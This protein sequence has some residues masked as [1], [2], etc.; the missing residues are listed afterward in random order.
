MSNE[1]IDNQ[2]H[3]GA[4]EVTSQIMKNVLSS[5]AE[6]EVGS[7]F[8][9]AKNACP[10]V[11]TLEFLGHQQPEKGTPII[12]DNLACEGILKGAVKQK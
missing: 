8:N 1:D 3:N 5:A 7:A 2:Q 10:I 9:N 11:V 12:T 6:A 4:V